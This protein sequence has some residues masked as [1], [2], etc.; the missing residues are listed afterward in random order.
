LRAAGNLAYL[1]LEKENLAWHDRVDNLLITY[2]HSGY[3][4]PYESPSPYQRRARTGSEAT[5]IPDSWL[6]QGRDWDSEYE[7][8]GRERGGGSGSGSEGVVVQDTI[9]ATETFHVDIEAGGVSFNTVRLFHP[10]RG[11]YSGSRLFSLCVF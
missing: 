4:S 10:R 7:F 3:Q 2:A 6:G 9:T 1:K 11:K 5:A 8:G